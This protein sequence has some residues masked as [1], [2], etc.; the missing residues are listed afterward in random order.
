MARARLGV[1]LLVPAPLDREVDGLRRALRDTS[2]GRIPPHLTLVPPVNVRDE[3]RPAALEVL[4]SAGARIR[5][6][7]AQLGPAATFGRDSPVVY[8][9]VGSGAAEVGALRE[10]VRRGPLERRVGWPFVPHVTLAD[11]ATPARIDAAVTA[12][13]DWQVRA[14]FDRVHLLEEGR[15]RV[16]E[17]VA[18]VALGAPAVV[19]RGGLP[20]ELAVSEQA[21]REV[22]VWAAGVA[23][24]EAG[25]GAAGAAGVAAGAAGVAAGGAGAGTAGGAGVPA[26]APGAPSFAVTARQAGEVVGMAEGRVTG[27]DCDLDRLLVGPAQRGQ[28]VGSHLLAAVESLAAERGCRRCRALAASRSRGEAF[29]VGRGWLCTGALT[30]WLA[31]EDYARLERRLRS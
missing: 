23:A 9:S 3:D 20:V 11:G 18:E 13:A 21:D 10:L 5:P 26:G 12:L 1:A 27:D 8:L 30:D 31:G 14:T 17:P 6:F 22:A 4:R 16:W 2:L 15:G 25:T 29:L 19:G 28:G 24:G 7:V